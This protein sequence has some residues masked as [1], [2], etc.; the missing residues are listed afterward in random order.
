[1]A[2]MSVV[3][4][5]MIKTAFSQGIGLEQA[6]TAYMLPIGG[7]AFVGWEDLCYSF[8]LVLLKR[9]LGT[10]KWMWP[11]H[12]L[13]LAF[14][15]LSFFTGHTYQGVFAAAMISF[16]IPYAVRFIEKNGVTTLMLGHMLYD[17]ATIMT[18]R[19]AVGHL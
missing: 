9:M 5:F 7:T 17:F 8:P 16:Y 10:S 11:V 18:V 19:A 6:Q 3:R 12:M 4:Y 2:C 14:V 15:M 1:M 13:L